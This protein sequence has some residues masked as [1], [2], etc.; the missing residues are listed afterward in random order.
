MGTRGVFP[1]EIYLRHN[2]ERLPK[3]CEERLDGNHSTVSG[4][5][6]TGES[7]EPDHRVIYTDTSTPRSITPVPYV[8][9]ERC[10]YATP[11]RGDARGQRSPSL[12]EMPARR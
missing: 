11:R 12:G 6:L 5:A 4:A 3:V 1:A 8:A 2:A 7:V 9:C 10:S